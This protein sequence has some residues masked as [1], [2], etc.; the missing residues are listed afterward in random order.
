MLGE[1]DRDL[2]LGFL[3]AHDLA[4][5]SPADQDPRSF[6][7]GLAVAADA[8][9]DRAGWVSDFGQASGSTPQARSPIALGRQIV[10]GFMRTHGVVACPPA[11]QIALEVS[12]AVATDGGPQFALQGAV[13]SFD[14]ALRLRVI[15]SAMNWANVQAQKLGIEGGQANAR[16]AGRE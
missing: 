7:A 14:L 15:R 16:I 6:P 13:E 4:G 9:Q 1:V 3:D 2:V 11:L 10:Q 5:Q 8:A 12:Q